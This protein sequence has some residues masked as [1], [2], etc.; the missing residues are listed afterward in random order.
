VAATHHHSFGYM[1]AARPVKPFGVQKTH[2]RRRALQNPF[3]GAELR[4]SL[5]A[6]LDIAGEFLDLF[7]F[8][9]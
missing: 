4:L 5:G 8:A 3:E 1:P 7:C 2:L 9:H 6:V